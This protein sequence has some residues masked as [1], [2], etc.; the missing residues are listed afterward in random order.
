MGN[1]ACMQLFI[2]GALV[3]CPNKEILCKGVL[4][5]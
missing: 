4:I 5:E 3:H 1:F 2:A